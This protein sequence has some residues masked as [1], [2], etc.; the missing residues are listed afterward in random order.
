MLSFK[1]FLLES[2]GKLRQGLSHISDLK[3]DQLHN[4]IH[5][6]KVEGHVTEKSDGS[7]FEIG[8]DD[9]GFYT[10]TSHSNKMRNAGD[11]ESAAREKFGEGFNP[12]ISRHFDRIHHELHSNSKLTSYLSKSPGSSIKGEIFYKPHGKPTDNGEVRFVG[13]AYDPNKM[14]KTG[15]FIVHSKLPEN[16][17]HDLDKVKSLSDDNWKFDDDSTGKHVSVD[18]SDEK[19]QLQK[20]NPEILKSRKQADKESKV[21]EQEK[22]KSIQQSVHNKIKSH[23]SS[24][25]PKWGSETEGYV[26]HPKEG[27]S[28]PRVKIISDTFKQNKQNFKVGNK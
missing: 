14:G 20:I 9:Q 3:H 23:L 28:A 18:V 24:L 21:A 10:R 2:E 27:S 19:H 22:L 4:L 16:K 13:T 8:H 5:T 11:Y 12:E 15:S 17:N 1:S 7:A 26:I 25:A 6:G